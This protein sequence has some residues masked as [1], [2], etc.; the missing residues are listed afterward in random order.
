MKKTFC[1]ECGGEM[2]QTTRVF[3]T[4]TRKG[5]SVQIKVD[6]GQDADICDYCLM[7]LIADKLNK[8]VVRY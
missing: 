5:R 8:A 1:D 7:S 6:T 4:K 3:N 2:K